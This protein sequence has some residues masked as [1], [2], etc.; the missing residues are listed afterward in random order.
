MILKSIR[1]IGDLEQQCI[2][3]SAKDEQYITDD[4]LI[5]K[6]SASAIYTQVLGSV[7]QK[8][9]SKYLLPCVETYRK[10]NTLNYWKIPCGQ[11]VAKPFIKRNVQRLLRKKVGNKSKII[12]EA[13]CA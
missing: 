7:S 8:K 9:G 2:S 6:N 4:F 11:S 10:N 12:A 13:V 1:Y 5:T 3:V